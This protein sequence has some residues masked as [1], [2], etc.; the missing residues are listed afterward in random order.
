[1]FKLIL[2]LKGRPAACTTRGIALLG[3]IRTFQ[4]Y[5]KIIES[6]N[7]SAARLDMS[8]QAAGSLNRTF[9]T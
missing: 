6:F 5:I 2:P 4:P 1:M 3:K 8:C 9:R 7:I